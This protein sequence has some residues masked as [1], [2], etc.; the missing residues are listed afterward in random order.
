MVGAKGNA[1]LPGADG[2]SGIPGERGEAGF[3]GQPGAPGLD[4]PQGSPGLPGERGRDGSPGRSR[5]YLWTFMGH[6]CETFP[7][8]NP[9]GRNVVLEWTRC[10]KIFEIV[11]PYQSCQKLTELVYAG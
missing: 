5:C 8:L 10:L 6:H 11:N 2:L 9:L 4:G 7:Y 1:G 3:P